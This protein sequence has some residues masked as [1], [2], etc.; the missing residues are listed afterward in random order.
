[1]EG[2]NGSAEGWIAILNRVVMV[3][4]NYNVTLEQRMEGGKGARQVDIMVKGIL[5]RGSSP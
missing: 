4:L 2:G 1:M 3:D 5:G